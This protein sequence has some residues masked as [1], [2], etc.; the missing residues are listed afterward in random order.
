VLLSGIIITYIG[1][2][3]KSFCLTSN[4]REKKEIFPKKYGTAGRKGES[5]QTRDDRKK[6]YPSKHSHAARIV[7]RDTLFLCLF[8]GYFDFAVHFQKID[9]HSIQERTDYSQ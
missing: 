7:F 8:P 9:I 6:G 3:F 1:N 2:Y 5:P 4:G